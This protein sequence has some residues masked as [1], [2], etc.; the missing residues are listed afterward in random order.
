MAKALDLYAR[1]EPLIPYQEE[2]EGLHHR[3]LK[4]LKSHKIRTLLDI[5]CGSGDLLLKAEMMGVEGFGIDL[6]SE[7]IE[8]AQA[9]GAQAEA[10]DLCDHTGHYDA[11]TA[12]FDVLNYLDS[13][14]LER[15]L[16]CVVRV[17]SEG[18]IFIADINT[19][20]GFK[21]IAQGALVLENGPVHATVDSHYES[22]CLTSEIRLFEP[23]SEGLYRRYDGEILQYYHTEEEIIQ[24]A[25][26]VGLA[27][28]GRE[29]IAL[30]GKKP[31][32]T[33]LTFKRL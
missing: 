16:G 24:V 8:R 7:M 32:K 19:L 11:A 14:A 10:I 26:K 5:G 3:Y 25:Q 4:Q 31:D 28:H 21:E 17:L 22:G 2:I 18:G 20:Y 23:D 33:L 9:A 29:S 12:V 30:Y 13:P 6:S 1:I 27:L 15:F